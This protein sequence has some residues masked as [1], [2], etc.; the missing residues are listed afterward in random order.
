MDDALAAASILQSQGIA[1]ILTH[2]GENV[3]DAKESE[4]VTDHYLQL[5]NHFRAINMQSAISIK[6][7]Q[8]GLDL[9]KDLCRANL[10]RLLEK[11]APDRMV[12]IDME[13]S[14]YVDATLEIFRG[15]RLARSN[16][17]VCLQA[18]LHRTAGD[19]APLIELG[20]AIRLV[21]G[22]YKEPPDRA[23]A[24]KKKV[25]DNFFQLTKSLLSDESR[26]AGAQVAVATHDRVLIRKI[27]EFAFESG[28]AKNSFE[29]QMLYGIQRAEQH[30]LVSEGW[31]CGVLI[32]YGQYWF[33]WFMRRLAER[34]ANVLFLIRNILAT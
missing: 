17:G 5:L 21:K 26:R 6:L 1:T 9:D 15:A 14:N 19:L 12:W 4:G 10:M 16:V 34:P 32:N 7:T 3:A 25:D 33:P 22:A 24:S 28:R 11:S 30:R 8:L 20:A 23:F 2:L 13:S 31:R 18:C 29:F 27:Q